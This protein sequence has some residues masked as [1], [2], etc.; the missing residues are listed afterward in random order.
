M[1]QQETDPCSL[2]GRAALIG[3]PTILGINASARQYIFM[4]GI[5]EVQV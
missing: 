4:Y 5:W 2:A 1:Q 3:R